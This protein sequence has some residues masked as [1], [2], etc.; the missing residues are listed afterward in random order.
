M[1]EKRRKPSAHENEPHS[2][3]IGATSGKTHEE[4]LERVV[5]RER[6][7]RHAGDA[8]EEHV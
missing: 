6:A 8:G 2:T 3:E 4:V 5:G 7:R 1:S